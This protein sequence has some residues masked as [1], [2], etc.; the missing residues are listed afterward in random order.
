[1]VLFW[2]RWYNQQ[3]KGN[4]SQAVKSESKENK[5]VCQSWRHDWRWTTWWT[6]KTC[7]QREVIK[8]LHFLC[9]ALHLP[10]STTQPTRDIDPV[11]L[12]CWASVCDAGPTFQQHRVNISRLLGTDVLVLKGDFHFCI[13]CSVTVHLW[14]YAMWLCFLCVLKV[15]YVNVMCCTNLPVGLLYPT[16]FHSLYNR[17]CISRRYCYSQINYVIMSR[18]IMV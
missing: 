6:I 8:G 1:M 16:K 5:Y 7:D 4:K 15:A 14:L 18:G 9:S 2:I 12:Q 3:C 13:K 17:V 11:L 10:S